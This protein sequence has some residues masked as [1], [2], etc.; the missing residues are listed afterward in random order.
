VKGAGLALP[1][2]GVSPIT[3]F[4]SLLP[5]V[6][7]KEKGVQGISSVSLPVYQVGQFCPT[8]VKLE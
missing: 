1:G 5:P 2:F 4:S 6:A 7:A 3:F 8:F